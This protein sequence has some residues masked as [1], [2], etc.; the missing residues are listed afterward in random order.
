MMAKTE[1]LGGDRPMS[2]WAAVLPVVLSVPLAIIALFGLSG[3]NAVVKVLIATDTLFGPWASQ[4]AWLLAKNLLMGVGG[5]AGVL[6]LKPWKVV[7]A[8]SNEP[9][10]DDRSESL[11]VAV[12]SALLAV[13][14]LAGFSAAA[15]VVGAVLFDP[16]I[17]HP[18]NWLTWAHLGLFLLI[19]G[20]AIWGLVKLKP[21]TRREPMSP[22][23]RRTN[24]L[25]AISG[26]VAVP[27]TLALAFSTMSRDDPTGLFSNSPV[28]LWIALFA[29]AGWLL[30]MAIGW[31][32]Y[33]SADEHERDAY[34]FGSVVGAGLFTVLTPAWW[35][36]ARAGL[37]PRP[38]AMIL[39]LITMIVI[40]IGWF[41][42][43]YR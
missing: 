11:N 4:T 21:W 30:G 38:D 9:R 36:A 43:R 19:A 23:T 28:S 13:L 24:N 20:G 7:L 25:F 27:G 14:V 3:I 33:F 29:I 17:K 34:D 1:S 42:H 37:V 16:R 18:V 39:W 8:V 32:W 12:M 10:D 35:V 26:L 5:I 31:W 22:S 40:T 41:W 2:L 6:W 15:G